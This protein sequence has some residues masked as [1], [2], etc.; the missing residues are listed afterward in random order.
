[1]SAF[2][3]NGL[4]D[5]I[6]NIYNTKELIPLHAPIFKGNEK[7]FIEETIDS[8]F[9][10]TVGK[11]VNDFERDIASFVGTKFAV[12]TSSGT[13]ALHLALLVSGCNSETEVITQSLSFVAG[14]NAIRYCQS[15]PV[16]IDVDKDTLGMSPE[17]LN[18]FLVNECEVRN[19]GSCWNKKTSR[20]IKVCLLTHVYG[21]AS[22]IDEIQE[23]CNKFN[24]SVIEDAAESLGSY[25]KNN[26]LGSTS[27]MATFSFNGNKIITSGG[28][29][30]VVTN[31]ESLSQKMKHLS[32]TAKVPHKWNFYHN[33]IGYNYRMPNINA[34]LGLAQLEQLQLFIKNKELIMRKYKNWCKDNMVTFVEPIKHS[35]P[36]FW[37]NTII[38]K[39]IEERDYILEETNRKLIQTRP[40]WN[41]LNSLPMFKNFQVNNLPNT[42]WL[43]DRIINLPSS[44]SDNKI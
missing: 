2:K 33:Y 8:T 1:M 44:V 14:C 20:I 31:D 35:S 4:I 39:N 28:G 40:A 10:S 16:F 30:M 15:Q 36:N 6:Q 24:I 7:K 29:G 25:Y 9:V 34:A 5:L 23:I 3:V 26:H 11:F 32:T 13:T 19:D 18:E 12:A 22:R 43:F 37:L 41:P 38:V 21:F 27:L 42:A 17:S